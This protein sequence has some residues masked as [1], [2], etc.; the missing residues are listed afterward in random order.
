MTELK[1][2]IIKFIR[3]PIGGVLLFLLIFYLVTFLV[4][5]FYGPGPEERN[6]LPQN[7]AVVTQQ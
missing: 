7:T 6:P 3:T 1:Q 2:K 4:Y 5:Y